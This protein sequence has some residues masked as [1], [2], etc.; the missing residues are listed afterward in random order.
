MGK[1]KFSLRKFYRSRFRKSFEFLR[2][3][4][5]TISI[6]NEQQKMEAIT[7]ITPRRGKY[8]KEIIFVSHLNVR[9]DVI[10]IKIDKR[11]YFLIT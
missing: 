6:E 8:T 4:L 10:K 5:E 7:T 1:N 9:C 11:K 2:H 3:N